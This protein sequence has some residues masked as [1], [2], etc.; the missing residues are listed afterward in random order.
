MLLVFCKEAS[1][2]VSLR[3]DIP[4]VIKKNNLGIY[5]NVIPCIQSC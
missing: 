5:F 3:V 4:S 2:Q 1:K